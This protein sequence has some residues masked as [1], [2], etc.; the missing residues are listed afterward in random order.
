MINIPLQKV[1]KSTLD[2]LIS[3]KRWGNSDRMLYF[4]SNQQI[5]PLQCNCTE[6]EYYEYVA[7]AKEAVVDKQSRDD[8]QLNTIVDLI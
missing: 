1:Q 6:E 5:K 7:K 8:L 3:G 2:F 4:L